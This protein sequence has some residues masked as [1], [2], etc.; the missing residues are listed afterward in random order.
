MAIKALEGP[1]VRM[2]APPT[3][4]EE[5]KMDEKEQWF[6]INGVNNDWLDEK[7]KYL[8]ARFNKKVIGILNASYGLPSDVVETL[9]Q[10]NFDVDTMS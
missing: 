7:C 3:T 2:P 10:R 4:D 1:Y 8:E 6:F 5:R 9:H